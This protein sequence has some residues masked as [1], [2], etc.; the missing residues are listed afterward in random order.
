[1]SRGSNC[2]SIRENIR[3]L[4]Q[5]RPLA[6]REYIDVHNRT[7]QMPAD[8]HQMHSDL[9]TLEVADRAAGTAT[10]LAVRHPAAWTIVQS[11]RVSTLGAAIV[12]L[13]TEIR[14]K[15]QELQDARRELSRKRERWET[16]DEQLAISSRALVANGCDG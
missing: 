3:R 16:I 4:N 9:R 1:M 2:A 6:Y 10:G 8:I 15:E 7:Q 11:L 12:A 14:A 13:R 5:E